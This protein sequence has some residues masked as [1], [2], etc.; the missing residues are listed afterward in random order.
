M[1]KEYY[2]AHRLCPACKSDSIGQTYVGFLQP[3]DTNQAR[4]W[5]CGWSGIVDDLTHI[6]SDDGSFLIGR[7][8]ICDEPIWP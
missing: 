1:K 4:C 7:C 6:C 5:S 2:Q 8:I 3:P